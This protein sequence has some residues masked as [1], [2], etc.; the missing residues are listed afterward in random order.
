MLKVEWIRINSLVAWSSSP[1]HTAPLILLMS[2]I[3]HLESEVFVQRKRLQGIFHFSILRCISLPLIETDVWE[4]ATQ[5][6]I[7]AIL[8]LV[9]SS[10]DIART[11]D[12]LNQIFRGYVA[13]GY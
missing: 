6:M 4:G 2:S 9:C 8:P 1:K 5:Q 13:Y 10:S 12:L 3:L 7:T 11:G